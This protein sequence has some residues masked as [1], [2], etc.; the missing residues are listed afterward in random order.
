MTCHIFGGIK[1]IRFP[2]SFDGI[3]KPDVL[4][5]NS[6][7]ENFDTMYKSNLVVYNTSVVNW[8]PPAILKFSCMGMSV[9]WFP[10]D[11]QLCELKFSSWTYHGLAVNLTIEYPKG[12]DYGKFFIQFLNTVDSLEHHMDLSTYIVN[13]EWD[14]ISTKSKRSVDYFTCC[15]EPYTTIMYHMHMRRRTLYY[16]MHCI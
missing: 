2:S 14:L 1:D 13:G 16:G 8:I 9:T 7:D 5:Y 12:E 10:F 6:V 4:L 11:D 15:P 3:W